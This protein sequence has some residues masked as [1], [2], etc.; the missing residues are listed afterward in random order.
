M[1][2]VGTYGLEKSPGRSFGFIIEYESD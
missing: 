2:D 1:D